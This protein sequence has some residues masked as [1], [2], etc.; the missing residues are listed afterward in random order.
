MDLET[1]Y[2]IHVWRNNVCCETQSCAG[3]KKIK[4][5]KYCDDDEMVVDEISQYQGIRWP[6]TN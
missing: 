2:S 5:R 4:R 1:V 3:N 6:L